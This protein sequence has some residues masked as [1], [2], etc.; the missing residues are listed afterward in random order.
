MRAS[1]AATIAAGTPGR[2][3]MMRAA[4]GVYDAVPE[5]KEPVAIV[6]GS[7]NNAGDGYA[8]ALLL[9]EAGIDCTVFCVYDRFSEDGKYY[10]DK[11][12]QI[13]D[14]S[15]DAGSSQNA[16]SCATLKMCQG[17]QSPLTQ[18]NTVVDCL[19]GTGFKGEVR[20][21]LADV[22][23][24]INES[25]AFVVSVDIN[26]GLNGDTGMG[27]VCV[28]S[29]LTVSVGGFKPGHFLNMA[30][31]VMKDKVNVDIGI[32]PV[33]APY[34]LL[35]SADVKNTLGERP[36]HSNKGTY[37]Y[38]ALIG[39]STRYSGAIRLAY[40]ANAAMRSGAG[41]VKVA[42]PG[43]LTKDVTPHILESTLFPLSDTAI[44]MSTNQG[45]DM[46]GQCEAHAPVNAEVSYVPAEIDELISNV[47]TVAFGMGIGTGEGAEAI[48]TH[49]IDKYDGTLII[50]ADG[51]T[52]LS[53][54]DRSVLAAGKG[55]TVLTPHI[56]EFSRLTGHT[57]QQIQE[58]PTGIAMTYA[59]ETGSVVLLKGPST[60]V[61][62][63]KRVYITDRGCAGMATAGSGDVLSGIIAAV[64]AY[65]DDKCLAAAVAAYIN[66]A[67]GEAASSKYGDISMIASDTIAAI[68]EIIS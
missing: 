58:D 30:K 25:G 24:A 2:E 45:V 64:C 14:Q 53:R 36:N 13:E 10:Y 9:C 63:G 60:I 47:K 23:K 62:D 21:E 59:K 32:K 50:D 57:I 7:G 27:E 15:K 39:G 35:E 42:L 61:T 29:D 28:C 68:P 38:T 34:K 44:V 5:W 40:L 51:L 46:A 48:L 65:V 16:V 56:K 37:G 66:G 18:Y 26:S 11:L 33:D 17:E 49:L 1:D 19:L 55:A 3:L 8:L 52:L 6:C 43:S 20:A 54:M 4:R 41:V 67:A 12:R 22:I 31:D